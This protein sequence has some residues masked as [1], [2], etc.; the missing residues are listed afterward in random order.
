M[1]AF[2][3]I[4]LFTSIALLIG[5][6]TTKTIGHPISDLA[7]HIWSHEWVW[8]SLQDGHL[9]RTT[10]N[11]HL[12]NGGLLWHIDPFGSLIYLPLRIFFSTTIAWNGMLLCELWM[13]ALLL[14]SIFRK[15]QL[16]PNISFIAA[17][18]L[19]IS[20]YSL[21][22]LHSG[23]SEYIN[24]IFPLL[25]I[26]RQHNESVQNP[27]GMGILLF[28]CVIQAPYYALFTGL[29]LL[30]TIRKT[31]EFTNYLYT[32]GFAALC[33]APLL[34]WIQNTFQSPKAAFSSKEAPGWNF[35]RLPEIDLLGWIHP[36]KWYAPDTPSLGN[37]G[38]VQIYYIGWIWLVLVGYTIW[39]STEARSFFKKTI[40]FLIVC[41]GPTLSI[42]R[43]STGIPL[44]LSLFYQIEEFRFLHHPYRII[45][46]I[47][48]I[49]SVYAVY[50]Y[51]VIPPKVFGVLLSLSLLETISISPAV[52]PLPKTESLHV[53]KISSLAP[54]NLLNWPPDATKVRRMALLAQFSH[55]KSIFMGINTNITSEI[56]TDSTI[57]SLY[58]CIDTPQKLFINRD[59]PLPPPQIPKSSL[60]DLLESYSV[61]WILF[62]RSILKDKEEQC[63]ENKLKDI[64]I[65]YST[66][67]AFFLCTRN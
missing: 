38:I 57:R 56:Y 17:L 4:L 36:G 13:L 33:S 24:I 59:I 35:L 2:Y 39:H 20:P 41:L 58:D 32:I 43:Y 14:F 46:C 34:V 19:S 47:I 50:A 52:W 53:P 37:P 5:F 26:W 62:H 16:S 42:N 60:N 1:K 21:G 51:S 44:P 49:L 66:T 55:Q 40:P 15:H 54:G 67:E 22:L 11:T 63:T 48:P 31:H 45:A 7:D 65:H 6:S 28:A 9:P 25:I 30:C 10:T 64:C 3:P 29:Y 8:K 12:P 18:S 27:I 23:L 61:K